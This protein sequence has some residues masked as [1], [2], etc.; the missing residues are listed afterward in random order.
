MSPAPEP[1]SSSVSGVLDQLAPCTDYQLS[2]FATTGG[3][4]IPGASSSTFTTEAPAAVEPANFAL[5]QLNLS[6]DPVEC[7]TKY[8]VYEM[9]GEDAD[10]ETVI[11]EIVGTSVSIASP[12]ACS[13]HRYQ[14]TNIQL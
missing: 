9:I 1:G 3:Q 6:F 7:A 4:E 2:I 14:T 12:P 5:N 8:N 13:E 11:K 10:T